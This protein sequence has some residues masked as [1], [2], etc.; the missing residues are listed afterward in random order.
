MYDSIWDKNLTAIIGSILPS[1]TDTPTTV[2]A[3]LNK[4]LA[5]TTATS[6]ENVT[7][8]YLRGKN[9]PDN[10]L[11]YAVAPKGD[12]IFMLI[13]ENNQI[14]VIPTDTQYGIV[15]SAV[16]KKSV[17]KIYQLRK[18]SPEK[19]LIILISS[20][21]DITNL[22]IELSQKQLTILENN[23]P[24]PLSII[25]PVTNPELEYLHRGKQS[26]AFRMPK[27]DWLRQLLKESGPLVAPSAN[28]EGEAPAQNITDAKKYF[29]EQI[30][31][32]L[33]AGI[34]NNPAST[35]IK[36]NPDSFDVIRNGAFDVSHLSM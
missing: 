27:T 14:A 1:N 23:W 32:Y 6:S 13:K 16:N 22:G 9:L 15:T 25:I 17:E 12:K 30:S 31:F 18:R 33:D 21:N 34:L 8:F 7:P 28:F 4:Q 3:K 10:M 19:P 24:N 5:T 11:G 29:S 20:I 2:Y 36:L 35:I 26:L